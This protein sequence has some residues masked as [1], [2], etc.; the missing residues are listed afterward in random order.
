MDTSLFHCLLDPLQSCLQI[1]ERM[2]KYVS[3]RAQSIHGRN[4]P[5]KAAWRA[6][7]AAPAKLPECQARPTRVPNAQRQGVFSAV[8]VSDSH[9]FSPLSASLD[10]KRIQTPAWQTRFFPTISQ[11]ISPAT[12]SP[13]HG[14][15]LPLSRSLFPKVTTPLPFHVL[16]FLFTLSFHI[17]FSTQKTPVYPSKPIQIFCV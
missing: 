10:F 15:T 14:Y 6:G 8:L 12:S 7:S 16:P 13:L 5:T 9:V 11:H 2:Q 4:A 3:A 1:C 17:A